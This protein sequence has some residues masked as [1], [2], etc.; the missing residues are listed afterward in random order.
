[1]IFVDDIVTFLEQETGKDTATLKN[2]VEKP[3]HLKLGDYSVGCFSF[4]SQFKKSPA[5]VAK[6]F[7]SKFESCLFEKTQ[8]QGP[9][10]NFFVKQPLYQ[11]ELFQYILKKKYFTTCAAIG[12]DQTLVIEY[13]SANIAKP[14]HMGHFRATLLGNSLKHIYKALGYHCKGINY[15]GDWG[16]QFGKLMVAYQTWGKAASLK[17]DPIRYLNNLYVKFH[18]EAEKNPALEDE[19][20]LWFQKC[21]Q[22]DKTA[23]RLWKQFKKESLKTFS[24][25]YKRLHVRFDEMAFESQYND[26]L[27]KVV[28]L[29][30][31]KNLLKLSEGAWV[32]SLEHAHL[33]TA[34]ILK[35]DGT[36][37][38]LT[39]DLAALMDRYERYHFDHMKY[40]VGMPQMLHFKQ[41]F[42]ILNLVG[43]T[44]VQKCK[45]VSF[46]YLRL[47]DQSMSSR[48]G[49][50]I[51]LEDVLNRSVELI[52]KIISEKNPSLKHK[53][54]VAEQVGLGALI[55]ADLGSRKIKDVTFDWDII[56]NPDGD[57]GPY[58]HY[59]YARAHSILRKSSLKPS[60]QC[61]LE[62]DE[63]KDVLH[64][65]EA[66]PTTLMA[67]GRD[68]EPCYVA[69]YLLDLAKAFNRFY[70]H[71]RVLGLEN[72]KLTQ[73]RLALVL[74][75]T[76][77]LKQ[78]LN[79]LG[80]QEVL[81]L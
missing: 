38:Y 80:I 23:L 34:L 28:E 47:K 69:S 33:P 15:L 41:L 59:T 56:L 53:E 17:K 40:V 37:L 43:F 9:Y 48:K 21:E 42:E 45:H 76:H 29:L 72:K 1:M 68:E 24:K 71:H 18:E 78:G 27:P 11:R 63:E 55:F 14:F 75:T 25:L 67:A 54:K 36:S 16:T 39:R 61:V 20:R 57:T 46:G 49:T 4:A 13:S 3:P 65:L 52:Q 64:T 50:A 8:T 70:N 58:V 26:A 10:L 32:V 7:S 6:L 62:S 44:W 35:K 30:K 74:A 60:F 22:N 66:F 19:A 73:S 2:L 12:K 79:I 81:E 51:F 5:E 31:Q 77:I